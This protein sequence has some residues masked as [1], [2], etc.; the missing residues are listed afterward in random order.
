MD[1]Q[2]ITFSA[3]ACVS[4]RTGPEAFTDAP[5]STARAG[6]NYAGP[7]N[8]CLDSE[9]IALTANKD[10]VLGAIDGLT[11]TGS[12]AG[13][14]GIAWGWYALSRDFGMWT[15]ASQPA[16]YGVR[17]VSKIAVIMTDGDFNTS[18]CNGVISRSSGNGSGN[19][20]DKIN[21]DAPNGDPGTQARSLCAAM[22]RKGIAIYTIGFDVE[23]D[24]DA[25]T[26]M[27]QCASSP[28]NAFLAATN[29][30]LTQAFRSIGRRVSALRLSR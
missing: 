14:V 12:T 27:T 2:N 3:S 18:Y 24:S 26:T 1:R 16:A 9:F 10:A 20:A 13:Q 6:W 23:E 11:A 8:P 4:E 29:A 30:E 7:N 17:D 21:C 25:M 5:P 19:R 15:G 22:K 28:R